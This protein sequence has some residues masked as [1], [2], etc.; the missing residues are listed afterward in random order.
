VLDFRD[1]SGSLVGISDAVTA[2]F[3]DGR[4]AGFS[5]CNTY[6]GSYTT[7]GNRI[8]ITGFATTSRSCEGEAMA[9]EA[10]YLAA[11]GDVDRFAFRDNQTHGQLLV[12]TGPDDQTRLRYTVGS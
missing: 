1:S 2:E 4:V 8:T 12:L 9:A 6:S 11:L 7:T 5:G 10:E 3:D